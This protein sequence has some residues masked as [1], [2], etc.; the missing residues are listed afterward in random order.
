[1]NKSH[2]VLDEKMELHLVFGPQNVSSFI[3][4]VRVLKVLEVASADWSVGGSLV[5]GIGRRYLVVPSFWAHSC[6]TT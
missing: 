4:W 5:I 6:D 3:A 1:M 2:E